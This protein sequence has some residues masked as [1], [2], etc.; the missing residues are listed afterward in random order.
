MWTHLLPAFRLTLVL[1]LLTAIILFAG[2]FA[3]WTV[4]TRG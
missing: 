3:S 4:K 1:T 2:V